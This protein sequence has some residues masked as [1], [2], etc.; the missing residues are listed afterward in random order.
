M[1]VVKLRFPLSKCLCGDRLCTS[2]EM[3]MQRSWKRDL[4]Q[5]ILVQRT[6]TRVPTGSWCRDPEREILDKRPAD[7][8][9]QGSYIQDPDA[10]IL[11]QKYAQEICTQR[12]C[13]SSFT[14]SCWGDPDTDI[15]HKRSSYSDL[16][17]VGLRDPA[18]EIL[19]QTSCTLDSHS[20]IS[21]KGSYSI[22]LRRS[23]QTS[24]TRDPD[25]VTLHK[26]P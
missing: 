7:R 9:P 13:T 3:L 22:L 23:W 6:C 18:E 25:T 5:E 4:A 24:C 17:Q 11:A 20:E 16:A 21:H 10:E 2:R 15:L 12:S 1:L 26:W 8:D 19:T 14:G